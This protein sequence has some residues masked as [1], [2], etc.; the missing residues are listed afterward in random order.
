MT[1]TDRKRMVHTLVSDFLEEKK[2]HP[3]QP[4]Y[5][6]N[7]AFMYTQQ[8]KGSIHLNAGR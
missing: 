1:S 3:H 8:G 6:H 7:A 2:W 4:C 5:N